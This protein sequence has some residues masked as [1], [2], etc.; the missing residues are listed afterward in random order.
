MTIVTDHQPLSDV[1]TEEKGIPQLSALRLQMWTIILSRY[2]YT[3][4]YK[5]GIS[6]RNARCLSRFPKNCQNG[7]S[8]LANLLFLTDVVESP[9]T[10]LDIKNE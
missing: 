9:V 1:L 8:K 7:F 6:N 10:S 5:I 2:N 4:K 3:L